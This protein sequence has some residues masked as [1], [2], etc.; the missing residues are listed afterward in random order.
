MRRDSITGRVLKVNPL[1]KK[2][3]DRF[4]FDEWMMESCE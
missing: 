1:N 4:E 2:E 3:L